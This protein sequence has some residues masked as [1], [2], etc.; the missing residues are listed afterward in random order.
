M[1]ESGKLSEKKLKE[2]T[3]NIFKEGD[4]ILPKVDE[5]LNLCIKGEFV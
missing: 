1:D 3:K 5:L 2:S 4:E